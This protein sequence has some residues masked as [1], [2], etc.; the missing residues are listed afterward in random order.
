MVHAE[1]RFRLAP[2]RR[3][4]ER[5]RVRVRLG[6]ARVRVEPPEPGVTELE[7][8][9][10]TETSI[11]EMQRQRDEKRLLPHSGRFPGTFRKVPGTS[12]K[13]PG[14]SW[15]C[16]SISVSTHVDQLRA[17]WP[18]LCWFWILL[19]PP[20]WGSEEASPAAVPR[21]LLGW[22]VPVLHVGPRST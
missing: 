5:C 4:A 3:V 12:W 22:K 10:V 9:R 20:C 16:C 2:G 6:S 19:E 15:S 14:T 18:V 11:A 7:N 21:F 8:P 1:L 17:N 13:V